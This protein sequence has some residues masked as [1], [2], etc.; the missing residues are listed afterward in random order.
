MCVC[1]YA[2]FLFVSVPRHSWIFI[3]F[4]DVTSIVCLLCKAVTNHTNQHIVVV[5]IKN[6]A[7]KNE[8]RKPKNKTKS[9]QAQRFNEKKKKNEKLVYSERKGAS[10]RESEKYS[11]FFL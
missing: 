4:A 9:K 6:T 3:P 10:E 5:R 2:M 7:D 8:R 11:L 1:A